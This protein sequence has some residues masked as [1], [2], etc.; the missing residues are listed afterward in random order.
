MAKK[1]KT[2]I[3]VEALTEIVMFARSY[4]TDVEESASEIRRI[5]QTMLDDDSLKGGDGDVIRENFAS[6]AAGC[7]NI[8]KSTEKIASILDKQLGKS[9]LMKHGQA[10]GTSTD[11]IQRAAKKAGVKK[12]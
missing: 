10:I 9:I 4:R 7:S 1:G 2:E 6:I 5:C 12:E 3:N 11:S 8:A